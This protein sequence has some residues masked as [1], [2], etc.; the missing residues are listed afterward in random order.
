MKIIRWSKSNEVHMGDCDLE[1][2]QAGL[3]L[4]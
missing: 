4:E 1:Y 3:K 2:R